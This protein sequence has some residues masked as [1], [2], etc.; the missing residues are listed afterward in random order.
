MRVLITF[1]LG[2]LSASCLCAS[3]Y[4]LKFWT[5]TSDRLFLAFSIFFGAEAISRCVVAFLEKPGEGVPALY[6]LRFVT[7]SLIVLSIWR[8][9]L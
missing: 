3:L 8:K 4:F 6:L 7:A 1:L 5:K 2:V 9:N